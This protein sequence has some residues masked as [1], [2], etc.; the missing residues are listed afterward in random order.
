MKI[1]YSNWNVL[2]QEENITDA[3]IFY[4]EKRVY[5]FWKY[6]C[7]MGGE[8]DVIFL[9]F[10]EFFLDLDATSVYTDII[11][12]NLFRIKLISWQDKLTIIC[13]SVNDE[14]THP[15]Q[16]PFSMN[17]PNSSNSNNQFTSWLRTHLLMMVDT[18]NCTFT[19]VSFHAT[20]SW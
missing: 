11:K 6:I 13:E 1:F 4:I 5:W 3:L 10:F 20:Y 14:R 15:K 16:L 18:V 7:F 12:H 8:D 9:N 17:A 2:R 19:W